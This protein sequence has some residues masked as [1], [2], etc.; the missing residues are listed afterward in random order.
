MSRRNRRREDEMSSDAAERMTEPRQ[1][2][3]HSSRQAP[4]SH[5]TTWRDPELAQDE[6]ECDHALSKFVAH[7]PITSLMAGFGVGVGVG[8]LAVA[9]LRREQESPWDRR[10]SSASL[11]GL[12]EGIRKLPGKVAEYLPASVAWR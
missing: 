11:R 2:N 3:S 1:G 10:L 5:M 12:S 4:E 7:H 8:V 9:I 6:Q